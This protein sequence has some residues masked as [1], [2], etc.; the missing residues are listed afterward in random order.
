MTLR[1]YSS[2]VAVIFVGL[3]SR[4]PEAQQHATDDA[5]SVFAKAQG[6]VVVIKNPLENLQGSG[7]AFRNIRTNDGPVS[8]IAT[9]CHVLG[10]SEKVLIIRREAEFTGV[11]LRCDKKNDIAL[12]GAAVGL[13]PAKLRASSTLAIGEK[14]FAIGAP[15]GL[16]LSIT[17][18]IISQLR[19]SATGTI[20][21]TTA[22][23]AAGS[24]GGGLFDYKGELIG[25]TTSQIKNTQGLNFV[26]AAEEI[27]KLFS[28]LFENSSNTDIKTPDQ[29]ASKDCKIQEIQKNEVFSVAIDTCSI[30]KSSTQV[31]A[32][33]Y[34]TPN[35][36][37]AM[38]DRKISKSSKSIIIADCASDQVT[39]SDMVP[40]YGPYGSGG[41]LYPEKSLAPV[42]KWPRVK[43]QVGTALGTVYSFLCRYENRSKD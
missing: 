7:V 17:D 38:T 10:K 31:L 33:I 22:P 12:I 29:H 3:F 28:T 36:P 24:S 43:V 27:D 8:L 16:E 39:S 1:K 6:S 42:E 34:M 2:I 25:L 14:V 18:G 21:Q 41:Q 9:N 40:Y 19:P 4:S 23:I 20:I 15:R 5:R 37:I 26:V 30:E 13:T 11:V 32:I 35:N